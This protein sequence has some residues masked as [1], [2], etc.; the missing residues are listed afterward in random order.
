MHA[1]KRSFTC[2]CLVLGERIAWCTA[3]PPGVV[4]RYKNSPTLTIPVCSGAS[5]DCFGL[6]SRSCS[7]QSWKSRSKRDQNKMS[8]KP[9]QQRLQAPYP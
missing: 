4:V 7:L 1:G 2:T 6:G 8:I 9:T 5:I 3:R